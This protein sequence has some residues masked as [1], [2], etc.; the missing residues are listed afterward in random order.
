MLQLRPKHTVASKAYR[1][2]SL[3]PFLYLVA[4]RGHSLESSDGK[5]KP[6]DPSAVEGLQNSVLQ[7]NQLELETLLCSE[8][9]WVGRL[10][11]IKLLMLRMS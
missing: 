10:S 7:R 5:L 1:S 4:H 11:G 3:Q 6:G 8:K 2:F 9:L